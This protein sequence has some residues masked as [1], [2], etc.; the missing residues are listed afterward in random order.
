MLMDFILRGKHFT[1]TPEEVA[2]TMQGT[3]P[4]PIARYH[5]A[6][7]GQSYPPKQVLAQVTGLPAIAFTTQDAYRILN[8]LGF[9]VQREE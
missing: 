3:V 8:R 4:Q 7:G 6:V 5:V 9:A 2:Q 1:V